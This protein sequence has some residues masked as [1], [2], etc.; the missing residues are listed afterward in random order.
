MKIKH[1]LS[2]M[3]CS[4]IVADPKDLRIIPGNLAQVIKDSE[5]YS[6]QTGFG[7]S[8]VRAK[9]RTDPNLATQ[10]ADTFFYVANASLFMRKGKKVLAGITGRDGFNLVFGQDTETASNE[11]KSNG[12]YKVPHVKADALLASGDVTFVEFGALEL[13]TNPDYLYPNGYFPIRTTNFTKDVTIARAPFV[14]VS[15]G[16]GFML[17]QI[18]DYLATNPVRKIS[19]I[20][21]G[22]PSQDFVAEAL[23][24][25]RDGEMLAQACELGSF[26]LD[27]YFDAGYRDVYVHRALSGV[28]SKPAKGKPQ[29]PYLEK[30]VM[31]MR[32]TTPSRV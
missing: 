13:K 14:R 29:I 4:L 27:S 26:G 24:G 11:L 2:K 10:L 30:I 18:M 22:L 16:E 6:R 19:E 1:P 8:L 12:F 3:P 31:P 32:V 15:Y 17:G 25:L 23:K 28:P 21:I 7:V 9:Y 5:P 20:V